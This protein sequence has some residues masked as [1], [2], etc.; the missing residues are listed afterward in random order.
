MVDYEHALVV[1]NETQRQGNFKRY[2]ESLGPDETC[3]A[4]AGQPWIWFQV[5]FPSHGAFRLT[6]HCWAA[7]MI[8]AKSLS[9]ADELVPQVLNCF[10]KN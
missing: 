8:E 3:V 4:A 9:S 5:T 6:F 2:Q 1:N 10:V 7:L